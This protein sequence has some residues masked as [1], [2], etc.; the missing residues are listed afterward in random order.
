[1]ENE[2]K[3]REGS[4]ESEVAYEGVTLN[5]ATFDF[6]LDL[7]EA[8]MEQRNSATPLIDE[9]IRLLLR[10]NRLGLW[11][12][13]LTRYTDFQSGN[14]LIHL[15]LRC[16]AHTHPDC[17][18][19]WVRLTANFADTQGVIIT[20]IVPREA[21]E[22]NPVKIT[23]KSSSGLSFE[24]EQFKIGPHMSTEVNQE[25]Q[26]YFPELRTSGVGFT[27]AVWQFQALPNA[28]LHVDSDLHVRA[29]VPATVTALTSNFTVRGRLSM[30]GITG[31]IPLIGRRNISL[32]IAA[33]TLLN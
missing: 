12:G 24:T 29:T 6:E 9:Q 25:Y 20:D 1:M 5:E 13:Q 10:E 21:I 11:R 22:K 26:T 14:S 17:Q 18:F 32:Q 7:D 15:P 23:I 30:N 33:K 19:R 16:I 3:N 31:L 28:V 2:A 4:A 27:S 8:E